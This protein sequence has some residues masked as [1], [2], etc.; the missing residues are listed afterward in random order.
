MRHDSTFNRP[1]GTLQFFFSYPGTALSLRAGLTTIAPPALPARK[2]WQDG[3]VCCRFIINATHAAARHCGQ[4]AFALR[5][6]FQ[7][8]AQ[9]QAPMSPARKIVQVGR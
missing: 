9:T 4:S 6:I 7:P 3:L 1:S 2:L 5:I 8:L